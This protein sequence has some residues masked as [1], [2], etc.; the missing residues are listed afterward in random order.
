M[1]AFVLLVPIEES[2]EVDISPL[3]K[4]RISPMLIEEIDVFVLL[5]PTE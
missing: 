2:F 5:V 4:K 3:D 1:G